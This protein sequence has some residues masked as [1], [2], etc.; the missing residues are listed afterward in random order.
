MRGTAVNTHQGG[1]KPMATANA[2]ESKTKEDDVFA[3][4]TM[5][6]THF[7]V[8]T[9]PPKIITPLNDVSI[10]SYNFQPIQEHDIRGARVASNLSKSE[11]IVQ[12][13]EENIHNIPTLLDSGAND[14]CFTNRNLFTSYTPLSTSLTR[15][16]ANKDST[17]EIIGKGDVEIKTRVNEK[18]I[19]VILEDTLH[20]PDLRSNLISAAKLSKKGATIHFDKDKATVK[21]P[22]GINIMSA[23][24]Y[25]QL[26]TVKL[27]NSQ[28]TI[29]VTQSKNKAV[30]FG[31]WHHQ[32]AHTGA[33]VIREMI[34]HNLVDGLNVTG[35][36]SIN[37]ICEDCVFGKHTAHPYHTNPAREREVLERVHIDIWGP[38]SIK[39]VG[40]ANY[41]MTITD[42][43]LS[44]RTVAFLST[45]SAEVTLKVFKTYLIEAKQQTSRKLKQ[46]RLDMGK[47][48]FNN[49]W[50]EYRKSQ[51]L[52][53]KYTTPYVHQQNGIA[54]CA[55]HT[56]LDS[57]RSILAE[58]GM[59]TKYW[60]DA[61]H[62][63]VYT[64]NY[65][66]FSCQ[67][68]I[69]L[70][71]VW[72]GQR[73]NISHL[74]PFGATGYA[75]IPLDLNMSK[76]SPRSVKVSLLGYHGRNGYKLIDKSTGTIYK[77]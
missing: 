43:Y 58:S 50:E 29:L 46:V 55:M 63:V 13:I 7:K 36:L 5:D 8:A 17:F 73:Q 69:I 32:L 1:Y 25:D 14:H 74:R 52:E 40:G 56:I 75:H 34:T 33:G 77:S 45:K 54:E 72:F 28:P 61:V 12:S 41:F 20:T 6:N 35:E 42:G 4:M 19:T 70:A 71:E 51:G 39:S 38:T 57:T 3:F 31:T 62:T 21:V 59:P 76:L 16:S 11:N 9:L 66:P 23:T 18:V 53:F 47:E 22:N 44:Y 37:G 64:Q 24:R 67:P 15:L 26:Y 48:W 60:A 2:A 49:A 30:D 65:T 68:K 10:A 27:E